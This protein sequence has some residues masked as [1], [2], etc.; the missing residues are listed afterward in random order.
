MH[1]LE[2]FE[3]QEELNRFREMFVDYWEMIYE[4]AVSFKNSTEAFVKLSELYKGFGPNARKYADIVLQEWL[5]SP[6]ENLPSNAINLIGEFN[7]TAAIPALTKFVEV[8]KEPKS[9]LE[10][11]E[12]DRAER[13]LERIK[14]AGMKK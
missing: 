7:I 13:V 8:H 2:E 6:D 1:T 4:R 12:I 3:N 9:D 14:E 10:R 5:E 11:Y